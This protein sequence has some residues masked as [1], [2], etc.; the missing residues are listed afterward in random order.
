MN[1]R[2]LSFICLLLIMAACAMPAISIPVAATPTEPSGTVIQDDGQSLVLLHPEF[3]WTLRLQRDWIITVDT[4][5]EIEAN[6]PDKTAFMHL[7]AQTWLTKDRKP[8]AR[9]YVDYWKNSAYGDIF[10]IFAEGQLVTE[11]E[12]SQDKF[13]GPYVHYDFN[14]TEKGIRYLQVYASGGGPNSIVLTVWAKNVD[15]PN[16]EAVLESILQSVE[17]LQEK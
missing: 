4:G 14:D 2:L 1:L 9:A 13:G 12:I 5:F 3:Y 6:D 11:T 7:I 16:V 17:L 15:Y 8:N 10:P